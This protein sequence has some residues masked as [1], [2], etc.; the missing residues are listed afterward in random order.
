M[1]KTKVPPGRVNPPT[2]SSLTTVQVEWRY[3]PARPIPSPH[4]VP[5]VARLPP[6]GWRSR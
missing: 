6:V 1:G 2:P 5:S 4:T 3:M